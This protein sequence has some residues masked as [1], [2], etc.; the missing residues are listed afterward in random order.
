MIGIT[1]NIKCIF[2]QASSEQN[3]SSFFGNAGPEW[4]DVKGER[5]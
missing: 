4:G 3:A 1:D 5:H 2:R